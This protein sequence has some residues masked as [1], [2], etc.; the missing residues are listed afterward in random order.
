MDGLLSLIGT[1]CIV[2]GVIMLYIVFFSFVYKKA[3]NT[4]GL[5][6]FFWYM[7]L[8]LSLYWLFSSSNSSSKSSMYDDYDYGGGCDDKDMFDSCYNDFD[9]D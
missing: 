9:D 1:L 8:F 5:T 6:S 7:I 2:F 3:K 4:S